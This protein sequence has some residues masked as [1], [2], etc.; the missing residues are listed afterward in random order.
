MEDLVDVVTTGELEGVNEAGI[1]ETQE[2]MKKISQHFTEQARTAKEA[3]GEITVLIKELVHESGEEQV[4][5][6]AQEGPK[7]F[8]VNALFQPVQN[9]PAP[10]PDPLACI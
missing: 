7:S 6:K 10:R 2:L 8:K 9:H 1:T 5:T 4:D 3:D